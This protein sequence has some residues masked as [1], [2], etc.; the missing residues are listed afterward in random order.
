MQGKLTAN[1]AKT[2]PQ[3]RC[4]III[5]FNIQA[6]SPGARVNACK[7]GRIELF[8]YRNGRVPAI[9]AGNLRFR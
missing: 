1:I 4:N 9:A 2:D 7:N 3:Q 6:F 8:S 5:S